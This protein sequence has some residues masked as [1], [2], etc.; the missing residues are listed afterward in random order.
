M[1]DNQANIQITGDATGIEAA[2]RKAA[3]AFVSLES[4]VKARMSGIQTAAEVVQSKWL[5]ATAVIGGGA[6]IGKVVEQTSKL[7]EDMMNL[8]KALGF[9]ASEAGAYQATFDDIGVSSDEFSGAAQKLAKNLRENESSLN[10]MGLATRDAA[11]NLRPLNELTVEA[12]ELV[13]GYKAGTDRTIAGQVAFG[14]GF[15]MT[16]NLAKLNKQAIDENREAMRELGMVV[17]EEAVENYKA[18]DAAADQSHRVISAMQFTIGQAFMPVL[19]DLGNWFNSIGPAAITVIRG[20]LGGLISV[21]HGLTTRV[22]I[23][24]ETINAMVVSVA[25]P[26]MALTTSIARAASGDF[27]GAAARWSEAA[28]TIK[29]AWSN[30]FDVVLAKA[31][32]TRDRMAA[33]FGNP[34]E[35]AAGESGGRRAGGLVKTDKTQKD[36]SDR[37]A[38]EREVSL[39]QYFDRALALERDHQAQREPLREWSKQ[40]DLAFWTELLTSYALNAKDRLSIEKRTADLRVQI[41]RESA[42]QMQQID[43]TSRDMAQA[44]ALAGIEIQRIQASSR[45]ELGQITAMELLQIEADLER[46]R[47]E[48]QASALQERLRLLALDPNTNPVAMAAIKQQLLQV[49]L[50]YQR[51]VAQNNAQQGAQKQKDD[52]LWGSISGFGQDME[53]AFNQAL[54]GML[55]RTRTWA[56]AM[57]GLFRGAG[58]AFVQNMVTQPL[59]SWV[60][61]LARM[62]AQKLGF[63]AA[64]QAAEKT[65]S[66]STMATKATENMAVVSSNAAG[67]A[68]GAASSVSSIPYV[69]PIMAAAAFAT[70]LA[71]VLGAKSSIKS[72]ARGFDIPKG[73]NPMVQTHEEEMILPAH[74]ANPLREM[75]AQGVGGG[76]MGGGSPVVIQAL[77]GASVERVI[78]RNPAQAARA[79]ADLQRRGVIKS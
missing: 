67:A 18:Y 9:S 71:M 23:V 49:E 56:Q 53:G 69:G 51:Q 50:D 30:A 6:V 78:R 10:D 3:A 24:W 35:A 4:Q 44:R 16:S 72:A 57:G 19:T 58:Q 8:G 54:N 77:D 79:F 15:E 7:T 26:L 62:L 52:G 28:D 45:R 21:F 47:F 27:S 60:G 1:A 55:N 66:L 73:L 40:Q 48:V 2:A 20:V 31:Q 38:K 5:A 61:G 17:G 32:S 14:K 68:S 70:T 41:A 36:R 34:T 13:N 33:L 74:I 76:V 12:I 29:G 59:M 37:E 64:D 25:E 22:T 39:M 46:Q 11:G 75:V 42:Q 63:L 43:A 65:A